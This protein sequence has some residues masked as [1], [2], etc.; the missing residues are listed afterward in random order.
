MVARGGS[1][2]AAQSAV[3]RVP[4]IFWSKNLSIQPGVRDEL[5]QKWEQ[6]YSSRPD[7]VQRMTGRPAMSAEDAMPRNMAAITCIWTSTSIGTAL[8]AFMMRASS[9]C[10]AAVAGAGS[11]GTSAFSSWLCARA[12][13]SAVTRCPSAD[14]VFY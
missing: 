9:R 3:V 7:Y 8:V 2:Q 14:I 5:V 6:W 12:I 13:S 10:R 1:H 4:L 11:S